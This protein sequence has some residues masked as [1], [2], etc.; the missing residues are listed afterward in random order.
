MT[1]NTGAF[2]VTVSF[3][4]AVAVHVYVSVKIHISVV[5]I[6]V[7]VTVAVTVTVD[8]VINVVVAIVIDIALALH[9][10]V[11]ENAEDNGVKNLKRNMEE[12]S[13]VTL[14]PWIRLDKWIEF[15]P[16]SCG[17][18][19][20]YQMMLLIKSGIMCYWKS[21]EENKL[22]FNIDAACDLKTYVVDGIIVM[23][24][25]SGVSGV[26]RDGDGTI[27]LGFMV[28]IAPVV[29]IEHRRVFCS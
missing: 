7:G 19:C 25:E 1:L 21:P 5:A 8:T 9:G 18:K 13:D 10:F 14:G 12:I 15:V 6:V 28:G 26:L 20:S 22:K 3:R 29:Q 23:P 17:G 11:E 24:Q 4:L 27:L 16:C 2:H